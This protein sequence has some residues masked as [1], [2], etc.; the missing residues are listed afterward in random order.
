MFITN[1][2]FSYFLT[3]ETRSI[4]PIG[5]LLN[6]ELYLELN[7]PF[8]MMKKVAGRLRSFGPSTYCGKTDIG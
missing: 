3:I 4:R 7:F 2:I 8:Y 6:R 1:E 5:V